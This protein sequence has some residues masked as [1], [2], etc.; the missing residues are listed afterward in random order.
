MWC[1]YIFTVHKRSNFVSTAV[2]FFHF[3][4]ITNYIGD[5]SVFIK[6]KIIKHDNNNTDN[7]SKINDTT[8][9]KTNNK[10]LKNFNYKYSFNNN[11]S[12]NKKKINSG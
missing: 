1:L 6:V 12:Q 10:N 11:D 2:P 4:I 8:N 9:N 5:V 3:Q 7:N